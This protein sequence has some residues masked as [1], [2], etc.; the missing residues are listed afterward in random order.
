MKKIIP[1]ILL[2]AVLINSALMGCI[3]EDEKE[4]KNPQDYRII[5]DM[6]GREVWVPKNITRV[7]D[8]SDGFTSSVMYYLGIMDKL[9]GLGSKNL[10]YIDR[11]DYETNTGENYSFENGMNPVTHLYPEVKDLPAVGQYGVAVNYETVASLTPDVVIVRVGYCSMNTDEYGEERDITQAIDTLE[12]LDIPIVILYGPPALNNPTIDNI[13]TEIQIIGQIFNKEN[14]TLQLAHYLESI[15]DMIKRRTENITETEKPHVL[16]FGLSPNAR[17]TGGAGDVLC[18]DTMDSDFIEEIVNAKN[19]YQETG[20]WKILSTEQILALNPDVIVLPTDWGYH[21]PQELYTAPY[22]QNLQELNAIKNQRVWALPY[23]PYNCAKRIEYPIELMVIA[24][25]TYP[26]LF[27]DI[28]F[29][30]WVLHFYQHVYKVDE[31]TAKELRSIQWLD[32][33][34]EEN[35]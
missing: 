32:W 27:D 34:I 15:V 14:E 18:Q 11:Y 4:D 23:T 7:I 29:H 35:L 9:V 10:H 8:L 21:P 2:L 13:S 17:E 1:L 6:R 26:H 3:N 31:Q 30:E 28:L 19:A 12:A 16:L 5:N 20:G 25:A 22:Y 24:K 33:T